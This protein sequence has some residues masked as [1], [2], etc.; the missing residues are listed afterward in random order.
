MR[1]YLVKQKLKFGGEKFDI[2]DEN[3]QV[4]YQATGSFFQIPK[5]FILKDRNGRV[6]SGVQKKVFSIFPQF[7]VEMK[8]GQTFWF[9]K[10]LSFFG[11]RYR[12]TGFDY[13]VKG[14]M[15]DLNFQLLDDRNQVVAE[16]SKEIFHLTDHYSIRVYDESIREMVLSLVVA[17]DYV[18]AMEDRTSRNRNS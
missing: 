13:Q 6:V 16:I 3:W 15:W 11:D 12:L 5:S 9:K 17:I 4:V 18:E 14:N 8:N 2:L 7:K 10:G 1:E